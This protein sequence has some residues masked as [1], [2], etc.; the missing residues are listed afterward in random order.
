MAWVM[1]DCQSNSRTDRCV[2]SVF[3]G[4]YLRDSKS[5]P[6]ASDMESVRTE[7]FE[8]RFK[9][10]MIQTPK[11]TGKSGTMLILLF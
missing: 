1:V 10:A 8:D 4:N 3:V 7:D 9:E 2:S 11:S 5:K 6:F